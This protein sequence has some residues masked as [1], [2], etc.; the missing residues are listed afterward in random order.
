MLFINAPNDVTL[1]PPN[2]GPLSALT[3]AARNLPGMSFEQAA[4]VNRIYQGNGLICQRQMC[5][6]MT[7]CEDVTVCANNKDY[8]QI[9]QFCGP[10][11]TPAVA[12]DGGWWRLEPA[13]SHQLMMAAAER[14]T[15]MNPLPTSYNTFGMY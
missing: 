10:I 12:M 11:G 6:S 14:A 4:A 8:G 1:A 9:L 3:A 13:N 5:Q 15:G 7:G 2:A